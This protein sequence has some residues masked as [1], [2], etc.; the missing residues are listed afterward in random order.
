MIRSISKAG[1]LHKEST[2]HKSSGSI[3]KPHV[4]QDVA[5]VLSKSLYEDPLARI[6]KSP[7]KQRVLPPLSKRQSKISFQI[8]DDHG[9]RA[10][11][12]QV[13]GS[14]SDI[15]VNETPLPEIKENVVVDPTHV[16][17]HLQVPILYNENL[18]LTNLFRLFL[19]VIFNFKCLLEKY[20]AMPFNPWPHC[21]SSFIVP[22]EFFYT[23]DVSSA[24]IPILLFNG[25]HTECCYSFMSLTFVTNFRK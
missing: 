18:V 17:P 6:P 5:S 3:F 19:F 10:D 24:S 23:I 12:L 13:I 1:Q 7:R 22:E 4:S 11:A 15:F 14:D 8:T 21:S 9:N 16:D 20:F 2:I 25:H